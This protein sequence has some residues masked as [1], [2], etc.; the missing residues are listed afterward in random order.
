MYYLATHTNIYGYGVGDIVKDHLD[1]DTRDSVPSL[2]G[3]CLLHTS[4]LLLLLLLLL[5][6]F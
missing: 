3:H 6:F 1:S 5:L 4:S 2:Y